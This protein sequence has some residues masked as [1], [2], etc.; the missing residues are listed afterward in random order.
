MVR[1]ESL[2]DVPV[3]ISE[4]PTADPAPPRDA[5]A[6]LEKY[7][8]VTRAPR[9]TTFTIHRLVQ[10]ATRQSLAQDTN[11]EALTEA[12][13]W[14]NDAFVGD[15]ID[16]RSWPVLDPLASHAE[17]CAQ[18]ADQAGIPEPTAR[19]LSDLGGLHFT[20]AQHAEAAPLL[21]RA[22]VIDEK[23]FETGHPIVARDL[24]NLA[25]LFRITNRL[26]EAEHLLRRHLEIFLKFTRAT[27]RPHPHL[28]IAVG[29]YVGLLKAMGSTEDEAFRKLRALA[30]E[31]FPK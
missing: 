16:V 6:E 11:H 21:R 19:L 31:V 10:A 1:P 4:P 28:Q 30:P 26:A 29:N 9:S 7:S 2:F 12:L 18:Y 5:L 20:K 17:V 22:L 15:P 3:P 27:G 25:G 13:R 8:L 24:N 14:L 23:F